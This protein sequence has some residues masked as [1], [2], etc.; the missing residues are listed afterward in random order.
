MKT[1]SFTSKASTQGMVAARAG[2]SQVTV[3]HILSGKGGNYHADTREKV[4]RAAEELGYRPNRYARA[5]R[6][7]KT[8]LIALIDFGDLRQLSQR[9]TRAAAEA[10]IRENYEPLVQENFLPT[11]SV[12]DS[13]SAVF[14]RVVDARVEGVI[15]I[16]P[17]LKRD[18]L[19]RF[20]KT[21]IPT[22]IIG[23]GPL[24]SSIPRFYSERAWG[25]H[26]LARHLLGLGCR[27]LGTLADNTD[28]LTT[29]VE[30]AVAEHPGDVEVRHCRPSDVEN[31]FDPARG[32][33]RGKA[34]MEEILSWKTR[35]D[36]VLCGN[37]EWAQGALAACTEAGLRVPHDI[38]LTGFDDDIGSAF[39]AVPLTTVAQ[40]IGEMAHGAVQCLF[41]MIREGRPPQPGEFRFP[42]TM[43]IRRSCG[44]FLKE[45]EGGK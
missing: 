31:P 4:R 32:Y 43:I 11:R 34:G 45:K 35:P 22:V 20:L 40:P 41:K 14:Q 30:R 3:S 15:L 38:A 27:R 39:G 8:G 28:H 36:A 2:V 21:G 6:N 12:G 10:V 26:A 17:R 23:G 5:M 1:G 7:G 37:D 33:L 29:G 9:K 25:Y 19:E 16:H 42:G 18:H 24:D 13:E 44:A